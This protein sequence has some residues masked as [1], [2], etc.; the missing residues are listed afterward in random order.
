MRLRSLNDS[1]LARFFLVALLLAG[2]YSAWSGA[3]PEE[4]AFVLCPFRLV[5]DI[6]CPGCGMTRSSIALARGDFAAAWKHHPFAYGLVALAVGGALF[7][8]AQ[9]RAWGALPNWLRSFTVAGILLLCLVRWI[10]R[11]S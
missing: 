8:A 11:L 4:L 7:P 1:D 2:L 3:A 6:P 10:S 9:R 5:T